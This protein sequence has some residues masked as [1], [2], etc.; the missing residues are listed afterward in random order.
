MMP[1]DDE[2]VRTISREQFRAEPDRYVREVE[3]QGPIAVV[4]EH[5][6]RRMLLSSPL[7]DDVPDDVDVSL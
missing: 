3:Q 1:S 6:K 2:E 4:D 5:G 7:A